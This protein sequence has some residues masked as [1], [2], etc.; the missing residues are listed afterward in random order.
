M[1]VHV[2][3]MI[4]WKLLKQIYEKI[5]LDCLSSVKDI[6]GG[7][8]LGVRGLWGHLLHN[9]TILLPFFLFNSTPNTIVD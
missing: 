6:S 5:G 7:Q 8:Y 4:T 9:V 2:S 3:V 1:H